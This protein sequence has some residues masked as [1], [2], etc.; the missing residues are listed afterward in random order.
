MS[1]S[2]SAVLDLCEEVWQWQ[3]RESPELGTFCGIHQNDDDWDDISVE[4]FR[5]REKDLQDFLKKGERIDTSSCIPEVL[6]SYTLLLDNIKLY[7]QGLKFK[8]YLLPINYMEG[9]QTECDLM[10]SF[11][12]FN[13]KEDFNKY[14]KRLER[15]PHKVEQVLEAL[16]QGIQEDVVYHSAS[17]IDVPRQINLIVTTPFEKHGFLMPFRGKLPEIEKAELDQLRLKAEEVLRLKIIPSCLKLKDFIENI[18]FKHLRPKEG[19]NSLKDGDLWY[20]QCLNFYLSCSMTPQ[21]VHEL[22]LKEV[23]RIEKRI[24]ELAAIEGLGRTF[25]E[26]SA[27]ITRRQRNSF[28]TPDEVVDYIRNLCYNIIRPKITQNFKNLSDIPMIIKPVPESRKS[29]PIAY[30]Y[31]GTPDGSREGCFYINNHHLE[32]CYPFQLTAVALHE[33]EPGHHLQ[34]TMALSAKKLPNFRRYS[35]NGKYSIIPAKFSSNTAYMEGWGLYAEYLGEE[36]NLYQN[37]LELIGRYSCESLRAARLVVDS[38][39]HAFGWSRE[40]AIQFMVDHTLTSRSEVT[41]EVDRYITIPGQ[42]CAYKVGEIK[43]R[44]LRQKAELRLGNKFDIKE[45]HQQILSCGRIP[46]RTLEKIVDDYICEVESK[47]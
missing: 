11:M 45:F 31:N 4:A 24:L 28:S 46:L 40:Q 13:T 33:G 29:S 32:E 22:G 16:R 37:N 25:Q 47:C 7:L 26:I 1:I 30:Y 21:E 44:E 17:V 10:I 27:A 3:L 38:G 39:L 9:I 42:A 6:L 19:I 41:K 35:D 5:R 8:S 43:I 23:D 15:L 18:Y 2:D 36:L 20:Q 14:I 12:K 34:G